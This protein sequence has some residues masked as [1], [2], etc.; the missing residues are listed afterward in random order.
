MAKNYNWVNGAW[1]N[2]VKNFELVNLDFTDEWLKNLEA[3]PKNEKGIRK[4]CIGASKSDPNKW[5]IYENDYV[6][7]NSNGSTPDELPF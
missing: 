4:I 6:P 5:V 1:A 2:R 3:L 7:R